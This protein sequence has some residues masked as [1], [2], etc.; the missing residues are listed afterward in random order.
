[1]CDVP[2]VQVAV[3]KVPA[4]AEPIEAGSEGREMN[5]YENI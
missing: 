1:M 2:I 3:S 4:A 5:R